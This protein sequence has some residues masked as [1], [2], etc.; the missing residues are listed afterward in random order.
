MNLWNG[1]ETTLKV[2]PKACCNAVGDKWSLKLNHIWILHWI[3]YVYKIKHCLY[4]N[5]NNNMSE[6]WCDVIWCDV[7]WYLISYYNWWLLIS[8][9]GFDVLKINIYIWEFCQNRRNSLIW[10]NIAAV[11]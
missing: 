8:M 2:T 5:N 9:S 1:I 4:N 7:M 3:D 6:L 11:L 10:F